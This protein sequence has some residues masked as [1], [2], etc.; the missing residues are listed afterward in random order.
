MRYLLLALFVLSL[1]ACGVPSEAAIQQAI[2]ETST[3]QAAADCSLQK[4]S[5][6]ADAASQEITAF[7]QQAQLVGSTPRVGLGVPL[8]RLLDIQTETR[9][10]D[11][12][13]CLSAYNERLTRIMQIHQVAYQQFAAQGNE[14]VITQLLQTGDDELKQAEQQL[15]NIKAGNIPAEPTPNVTPNTIP[16]QQ[17]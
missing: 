11:V 6:Y 16:T 15:T 1:A 4:M 12:P 13:P 10:L 14:T 5:A 2:A 9:K 3:A 17:K 8:Q 7:R